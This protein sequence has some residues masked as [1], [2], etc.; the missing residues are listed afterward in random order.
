MKRDAGSGKQR[1][2]GGIGYEEFIGRLDKGSIDPVYLLTGEEGFLIQ[3]ALDRL[4]TAAVDPGTKDFNFTP[5]DGE[6]ATANTI[7]T[8]VESLPAF[9]TRRLVVLKN[10]E[11]LAVAEANR[12]TGYLKNPS[13]TTCF[14]CVAGSF[15]A[16]RIFFQTLKSNSTVVECRPLPDARITNWLKAQAQS[17]GRTISSD[18]ILFLKERLGRDLFA[19][20]NEMAK[21]A[22]GSPDPDKK[23]A[24]ELEDVQ[25]VCGALGEFTVY[26]LLKALSGRRVEPA[27]TILT[28]LIEE[29]EAPLKI[30]ST[31][32]YRYRLVWKVKRA[33][34]AGHSD[35]A[36]MRMFGLGHWMAAPVLAAATANPEPDLRWAFQRFIETDAGLKGGVLPPKTI[37][38]LLI[39]DLCSGKQKGIR[40]FLGRQTLLYL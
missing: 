38:E 29:G 7:L 11:Q 31:I 21:A 26:D 23:K 5:L 35:T 33:M 19:L 32:S 40:R 4:I 14:V 16:R 18:A 25:E 13:P 34:R 36:L 37:M 8:A 20:Q 12:L 27:L 2:P 15:D 17:L 6:T 10:A 30:L 24:I 9:A 3:S 39:M 22:I 28:R 1:R